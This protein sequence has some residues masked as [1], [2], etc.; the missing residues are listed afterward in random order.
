MHLARFLILLLGVSFLSVPFSGCGDEPP[1]REP[2]PEPEPVEQAPVSETVAPEPEVEAPPAV[3][4][5]TAPRSAEVRATVRSALREG[6]RLAQA[7]QHAQA[8]ARFEVGL[9]ADPDS[10][11]LLC[12]AGFA[13]FRARDSKALSLLARGARLQRTPNGRGACYYNL[14]RVYERLAEA[15]SGGDRNERRNQAIEAYSRS[16]LARPENPTVLA[17]Y[18]ALTGGSFESHCDALGAFSS[19][20]LLCRN[21]APAQNEENAECEVLELETEAIRVDDVP[22]VGQLRLL[23]VRRP[24][25]EHTSTYLAVE[26]GGMWQ[27]LGIIGGS[28]DRGCSFSQYQLQTARWLPN[29]GRR[30][31]LFIEGRAGGEYSCGFSPLDDCLN[32]H[33]DNAAECEGLS[34]D[35]EVLT[36]DLPANFACVDNG[37]GRYRCSYGLHAFDVTESDAIP[38]STEADLARYAV[39]TRAVLL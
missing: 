36:H 34:G 19:P 3:E 21:L 24:A 28:F 13:A 9:E 30:A 10:A 16:L 15:A 18:E 5:R 26:V 27:N 32:E 14:G 7:D 25:F 37:E 17:R 11:P 35:V 1:A 33:E 8:L 29:E 6:R 12:E 4:R 31:S 38:P 39:C 2:D 20:E 23:V 22:P